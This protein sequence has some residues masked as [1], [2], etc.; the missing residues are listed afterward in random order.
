MR[1]IL[2]LV[3]LT[4]SLSVFSQEKLIVL[5]AVV[6]DTIDKQEQR[7]IGLFSD[8]IGQNFISATIHCENKK[9]VMHINSEQ[10]LLIVSI[11]EED[12]VEN[13]KHIDKLV[14]YFK[15]LAEKQDS[16]DMGFKTN[17]SLPKFQTEL[18][19]EEQ[20]RKIAKEARAYFRLNQSAEQLGLSGLEKENY[21]RVNSKSWL[22]E[23][24]FDILK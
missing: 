12:I 4:I 21:I 20:K 18:L 16:L 7:D 6:G 22:A 19:N 17:E 2:S 1:V 13:S 14:S 23:I 8:I 3:L 5:H 15:S 10:G 11:K 24:L 9:Y